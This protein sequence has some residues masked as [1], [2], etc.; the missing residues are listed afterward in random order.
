MYESFPVASVRAGE[1]FDYFQSVVDRVFCPMQIHAHGGSP[2]GFRGVVDVIELGCLRLARV[3]TP[4][5]TVRR[6]SADVAHVVDAPYL[7][8]FQLKGESIWSQMGTAVHLKPGDFVIASM[9][10]PYM[11]RFQDD[12]DM[13]VLALAPRTMRALTPDPDRFLGRRMSGDD[14]DCGLLSSFVAQVVAR[15]ARLEAPMI[16]RVEANILD[17]LGGVLAAR[18]CDLGAS[19]GQQLAQIKSYIS[20]HLHDRS[21]GPATLAVAFHISIRHVHALFEA[22]PMSVGRYIRSLRLDASRR[23]LLEFPGRTLTDIALACGFYDLSHWTRCF[24]DDYSVTP[25]DYRAQIGAAA[26]PGVH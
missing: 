7:V 4:P 10:A 3:S 6:R 16:H 8:K 24:R 17:L 26:E 23:M 18:S 9:D 21:L 5:V 1:R 11:L 25:R 20:Q 14:A 13:P 22:E 15:M 2:D 12:Y 19:P